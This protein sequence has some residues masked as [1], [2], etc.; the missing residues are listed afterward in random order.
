MATGTATPATAEDAAAKA[1]AK[2]AAADEVH[3]AE[4]SVLFERFTSLLEKEMLPELHKHTAEGGR[5]FGGAV[6]RKSDLSTV[7]VGS[8]KDYNGPIYHGETQTCIDFF[9]LPAEG[10]PHPHDCVFVSSHEPCSMCLSCLIWCGFK[11]IYYF[12]DYYDSRDQFDVPHDLDLTKQ[13]FDCDRPPRETR[14][15]S[16]CGIKDLVPALP[17]ATE[18]GAAEERVR[19]V[20][21]LFKQLQEESMKYNHL[22]SYVWWRNGHF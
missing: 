4:P 5:I 8:N 2:A 3:P 13:L 16:A 18:R 11:T 12:F 10:R 9:A 22:T 6:L 7:I 21:Q 1:A 20:T 14:F 19:E 15:Y 17:S